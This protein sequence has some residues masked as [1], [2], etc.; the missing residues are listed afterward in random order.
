M[1][2]TTNELIEEISDFLVVY[3][4]SGKVGLNS[5]IRKAHLNIHQLEQLINIHFLMRDEV[6]QYVR[7]LPA[8]I[9]RFKTSTTLI[10]ETYHGE[11]RGRINWENTIKNRLEAGNSDR[12]IFSCNEPSRHYNIKENLVLKAFIQRLYELLDAEKTGFDRYIKYEWFAEWKELKPFVDEIYQKNIYLARISVEKAV[13][14]DRMLQETAKHR[15]PLYSNAAKL[16]I[17]YRQL[18]SKKLNESEIQKLLQETFVYP[19]KTEVLFE[20]Y[21]AIQLIK[22][23]SGDAVLEL[24]DGRQN[25]FASWKDKEFCYQLYHDSS[26]SNNLSF[27]IRVEEAKE[28]YH[29]LLE[30]RVQSMEKSFDIAT[31]VFGSSFNKDTLWS[32]RPDL[33][34]EISRRDENKLMKVVIGE[35]KHTTNVSYAITG[36]RELVDYM[37]FVKESNGRFV[38]ENSITDIQGIL[39][40]DQISI[41]Q[42]VRG[43]VMVINHESKDL[44]KLK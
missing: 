6:K 36:L 11:I 43:D 19:D 14:S 30:R 24:L 27:H 20:L 29:P 18:H 34:L 38:Y 39:F 41:K 37:K 12:T 40:L 16:F 32:G 25:L 13:I 28:S 1:K 26:G 15:N 22:Q 10:N 44:L 3:L 5:F 21:W 7:Q 35:V 2:K 17:L 33:I 23:N 4:K 9:R 42:P 31:Q 8:L